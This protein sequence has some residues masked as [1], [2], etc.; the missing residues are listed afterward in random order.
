MPD[1]YQKKVLIVG[2]LPFA[3][4]WIMQIPVVRFGII[5]SVFNASI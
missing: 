5:L 3:D 1:H 4:A 2:S